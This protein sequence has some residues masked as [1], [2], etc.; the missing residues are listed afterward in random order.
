MR[1]IHVDISVGTKTIG[2]LV[3]QGTKSPHTGSGIR[4]LHN[5]W[6]E[7]GEPAHMRRADDVLAKVGEHLVR[8]YGE[9]PE[10]QAHDVELPFEEPKGCVADSN[11]TYNCASAYDHEAL[12]VRAWP[13]YG[14]IDIS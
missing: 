5:T 11:C 12:K 13:P 14:T 8:Q 10:R 6:V 3:Y 4:V 7:L 2:V 1:D 9:W